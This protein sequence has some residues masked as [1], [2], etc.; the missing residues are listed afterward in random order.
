MWPFEK[1]KMDQRSG[2]LVFLIECLLNQNARDLGAAESPAVTRKMVDLLSDAGIGM[3][4]IP[5]PEISCLGFERQRAVG[6]SIRQALETPGSATC[7]QHLAVVTVD[8]IQCYIDQGFE[9]L[10]VLG[11]NTQSPACAVH[12]KADSETQ[13]TN[14]SGI[15]MQALVAELANRDLEIQFRGIQDAD[16]NLLSEDLDWLRERI[17]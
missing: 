9:V 17:F 4:Q 12:T 5:C 8:R 10:A 13:L 2:R 11:G 15:F 7:C 6:Q 14:Q 16:P 1:S 3:A